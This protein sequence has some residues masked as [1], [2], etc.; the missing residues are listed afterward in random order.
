MKSDE[1][2]TK[3]H[4]SG[5]SRNNWLSIEVN[6]VWLANCN[7]GMDNQLNTNNTNKTTKL[8]HK[9]RAENPLSLLYNKNTKP[10]KV[11]LYVTSSNSGDNVNSLL[12]A[13]VKSSKQAYTSRLR[14][15][16]HAIIAAMTEMA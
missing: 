6:H 12:A 8:K 3:E 13:T 16:C 2:A 4:I 7:D 1:K 9:F 14:P 11:P 10:N 15:N 5:N